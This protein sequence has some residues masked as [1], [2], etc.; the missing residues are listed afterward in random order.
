MG[1][2]ILGFVVGFAILYASHQMAINYQFTEPTADY[3]LLG[4]MNE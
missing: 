4:S 3:N 1:A 2:A